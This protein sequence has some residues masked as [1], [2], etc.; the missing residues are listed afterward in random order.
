MFAE[1]LPR[2]PMRGLVAVKRDGARQSAL[3]L[4]R[5]TEKRFGRR[6]IPLCAEKKI[7]CFSLLVDSAIEI[8]PATL[9]LHVGLIDPPGSAGL[10]SKSVPPL[11]EFRNI[12]L[13]QRM[14]VV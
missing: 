14:I 1:K 10:T 11:F 9:D 2:R 12:M 7:D 3:E 4:E 8:S 13:D 6:D 5:P